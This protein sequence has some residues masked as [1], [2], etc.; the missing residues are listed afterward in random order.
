V[1]ADWTPVPGLDFS[2]DIGR[3]F[4]WNANHV[5]GVRGD[6]WVWRVKAEIRRRYSGGIHVGD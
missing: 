3:Q 5:S 1:Q 6:R 2:T 4:I